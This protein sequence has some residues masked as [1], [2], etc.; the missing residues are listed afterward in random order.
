MGRNR[1]AMKLA[2]QG[3]DTTVLNRSSFAGNQKIFKHLTAAKI[4]FKGKNNPA[5]KLILLKLLKPLW[6]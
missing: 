1:A 5:W 4:Y 3:S 2:V 6:L